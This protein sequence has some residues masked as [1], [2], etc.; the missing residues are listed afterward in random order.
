MDST[1]SLP[2]QMS[3]SH[4]ISVSISKQLQSIIYREC[5]GKCAVAVSISKQ[6]QSIIYREYNGKCAVNA[7]ILVSP[8]FSD[9][10]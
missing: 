2:W 10:F 5:N 4:L 9:V 6:L 1:C 8:Y 3:L 7:I